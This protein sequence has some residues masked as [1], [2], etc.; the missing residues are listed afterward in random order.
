MNEYNKTAIHN[1]LSVKSIITVYHKELSNHISC[2]EAHDFPEI[3][4]VSKG[5]LNTFIEGEKITLTAGQMIIYEPNCFHGSKTPLV[6]SD[7]TIEII[8]FETENEL[9]RDIYNKIITTSVEQ[10]LE[11]NE[12]ITMA[13]PF[14]KERIGVKGLMLQ[15][16]FDPYILQSVKNKLELFLLNLISPSPKGSEAETTRINDYLMKKISKSLTIREICTDLGISESSLVRIIKSTYNTTPIAYF[17]DL[18]IQ[19]VKRL[20][21][22]TTLNFTEISYK[23]GYSTV[24]HLSKKFK[25]KTGITLTEYAKTSRR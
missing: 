19:E 22:K 25:E 1:I 2:G 6:M 3:V 10:R 7:A 17:S 5:T 20:I 13:L 8:S 12:I 18:K 11:L 21:D 16:E 14:F 15:E 9:N 4:Y 24:H 23:L